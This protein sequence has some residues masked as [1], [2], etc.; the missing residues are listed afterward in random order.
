M[1]I[2]M[3][4]DPH[5]S[6]YSSIIRSKG[7]KYSTRLEHCIESIN[8]AERLGDEY[9]CDLVVC[10][11]DFFDQSSLQAQ[12][13]TA[14]NELEFIDK[15]HVF[16]VG[17]HEMYMQDSSYNSLEVL[18]NINHSFDIVRT[19]TYS[20][21]GNLRLVYIPY[22]TD[23]PADINEI[24]DLDKN[25]ENIVFSH[26]DLAGV[27]YGFKGYVSTSGIS[28]DS[29][30]KSCSLFINGHLHN[31]G[32]LNS[33]NTILNIGNLTGQNFSEDA[34]KF[35][36]YAAILDT[37]TKQI[38]FEENPYAFNFYKI[39]ILNKSDT[40]KLNYLGD[41]AIVNVTCTYEL[42]QY[43]IDTIKS[44]PNILEKRL[45]VIDDTKN[46]IS[47]ALDI[48]NI[49]ESYTDQYINF[50]IEKLGDQKLVRSE[51]DYII[52]GNN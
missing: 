12:E 34:F 23:C 17:N 8:W 22:L 41:N 16:L 18:K 51:L 45:I 20:D 29:I 32:Y 10:L 13:I 44:I 2:L 11:G 42:K 3:Y 28:L 7:K 40:Y 39:N 15:P 50:V 38:I 1:N 25:K 6:T 37:D 9:D 48:E 35:N 33:S 4:S 46:I 52:G 21:I 19:P 14:L 27:S 5:I 47:D 36:H 43:V 49:A 26:N 30:E 24:I 31:G